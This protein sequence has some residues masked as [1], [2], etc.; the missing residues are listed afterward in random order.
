MHVV[1]EVSML[2]CLKLHV[3]VIFLAYF[4]GFD[5]LFCSFFTAID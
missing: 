4:Y 3:F 1:N 2:I 5:A